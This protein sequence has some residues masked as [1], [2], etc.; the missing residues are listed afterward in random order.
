MKKRIFSLFLA[1]LLV[2]CLASSALAANPFVDVADNAYYH[3]A[4]LWAY[5]ADPQVTNGI[6]A[7]H[8]GPMNTVTRGQAMTFL[9]RAAGCPKPTSSANPFADV[10]ETAYYR[11]AVLWAVE[12][13]ITN[14]TDASHFS[15]NQT[16]SRGH[17][18]T[19][20]Y[21]LAGSPG[22][23]AGG[24]E[25]WYTAAMNW[26]ESEGLTQN[27]GSGAVVATDNCP[28]ADV[29]CYLYRQLAK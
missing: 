12:L 24:G 14:G 25:K 1:A 17:I 19:F 20:L 27:L 16:C 10:A 13:G 22:V 6:D 18:I 23:A 15:P 2:L 8:F 3:D 4:V 28:R 7:T 26:E 21:R 9:W 5:Y 29:V 11:D